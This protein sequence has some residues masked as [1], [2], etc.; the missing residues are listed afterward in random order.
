MM[1]NQQLKQYCEAIIAQHEAYAILVEQMPADNQALVLMAKTTLAALTAPPA[2][3]NMSSCPECGSQ[4]LTWDNT[5]IAPGAVQ[6]G[7]LTTGDVSGLFYLGCD[8][9]S[10]T[11]ASVSADK[12]AAYLNACRATTLKGAAQ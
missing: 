10:H 11:V 12:V 4:S 8:E 3:C 9:C 7:R 1:N 5:V 6:N 2:L